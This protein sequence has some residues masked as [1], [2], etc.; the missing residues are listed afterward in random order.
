MSS[1]EM[2]FGYDVDLVFCIDATSSMNPL[3][4]MVKR[5]TLKFYADLVK[6]M[7]KNRFCENQGNCIQRLSGRCLKRHVNNRFFHDAG[8]SRG[9]QSMC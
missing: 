6:G 7:E 8:S 1:Y 2:T 4:D 5:N 3:I 9:F